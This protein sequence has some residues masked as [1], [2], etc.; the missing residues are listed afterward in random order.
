VGA[1]NVYLVVFADGVVSVCPT[2]SAAL[3]IVSFRGHHQAHS[4]SARQNPIARRRL[5]GIRLDR[6]WYPRLY[7]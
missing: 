2:Y 4:T 1:V 3:T 5:S 7:R 6:P